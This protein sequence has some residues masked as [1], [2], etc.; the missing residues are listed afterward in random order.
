RRDTAARIARKAIVAV[1]DQRFYEHRGV[2]TIRIVG[3][4]IANLREGRRAQGGSTLTQQLAGQSF[5]ARD[6]TLRRKLKEVVLAAELESTYSKDEIL[7]LYLN[8][9]YFGNGL[10]GIEAAAR[11]YFGTHASDLT[12]GQASLLAGLVKSPSAYAPTV[13]LDRA[14]NRRGLVLQAM[15]YAGALHA[16]AAAAAKAEPVVLKD[17][18][19]R[20]EEHGGYFREEVRRVLVGKFGTSCVYEGGL[21]VFTNI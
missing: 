19:N 16:G 1:E 12:L 7:E 20:D 8:K 9:I 13:N 10:H 18:L 3:S 4:A 2:D 15:G 17:G 11:G 14:I 6:K 21:R 5:L